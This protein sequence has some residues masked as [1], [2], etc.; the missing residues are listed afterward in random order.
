MG[1]GGGKAGSWLG[2][3]PGVGLGPRGGE[4]CGGS[5]WGWRWVQWRQKVGLTRSIFQEERGGDGDGG[6]E[7]GEGQCS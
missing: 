1:V 6:G 5:D 3:E 7:K 2:L 4:G